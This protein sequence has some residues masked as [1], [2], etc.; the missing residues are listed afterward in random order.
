MTAIRVIFDGKAFIPQQPVSLSPQSEA[1]VL[2]EGADL[3]ARELLD[4]SIREYYKAGD[5]EEDEAWG[6]AAALD[7][8]RAWDSGT[9]PHS[10][11]RSGDARKS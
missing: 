2:V 10:G 11:H 1:F 4:Q 9:V 6:R 5:D 7:S 3:A 8:H